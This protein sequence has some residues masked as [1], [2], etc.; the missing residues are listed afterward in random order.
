MKHKNETDLYLSTGKIVMFVQQTKHKNRTDLCFR[1][2]NLMF[3][4]LI[5]HKNGTNLLNCPFRRENS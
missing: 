4:Q 2:E 1:Q 5:K 3:V